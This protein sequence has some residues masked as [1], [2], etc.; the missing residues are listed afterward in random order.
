MITLEFVWYCVIVGAIIFYAM[1]DGF[2]LGVGAVHLFSRSDNDR[3]IF[4][5]AIGPVWDG[6]EVWL[7]VFVGALFAGFPDVYATVFSVF[8][9]PTMALLCALIFRAV[10][11]EFR[12]KI[13]SKRWRHIWDVV[14]SIAS[15]VI[16]FAIGL[17]M[18]NLV[19]GIAIDEEMTYVG[20]F[21]D[22]FN[23]Y[24]LMI[25]VTVVAIFAL[26]GIVYLLMKTEGELHDSLR[27]WT[28]WAMIFFF[29]CYAATTFVTLIYRPY[30]LHLLL[31]YPILFIVPAIALFA[32]LNIP[33]QIKRKKDGWA[34]L[35]SCLSIATLFALFGLGT[36][37]NM[38]LSS[39]N[40]EYS[41]TLYNSA[42]S[43]LTL[44]FL[45][46]IACIG[47]PLVFAYGFFVY[48]IFGGKVKIDSHSY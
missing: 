15:I 9:V 43:K 28:K 44:K 39:L 14:F 20:S 30:M 48:K 46:A 36:F 32:I 8:Y 35:S 11:I 33:Y 23:P 13:E 10:A 18:A 3:R 2:D 1:L 7:V 25:G 24:A 27:K 5:N 26:H 19:R 17:V 38:V 12:S 29:I 41:L 42:A 4:L 22:F 45:V 37:P 31:E 16:A 21:L 34:F 47:L 6:N 40:P